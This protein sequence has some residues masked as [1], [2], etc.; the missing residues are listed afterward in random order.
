[1][2][3]QGLRQSAVRKTLDRPFVAG[4]GIPLCI[5]RSVTPDFWDVYR[6]DTDLMAYEACPKE[7]WLIMPDTLR[8][9]S[10]HTLRELIFSPISLEV[11]PTCRHD[12]SDS[13]SYLNPSRLNV[14][15]TFPCH[16]DQTLAY[17]GTGTLEE[18]DHSREKF[19]LGSHLLSG[20][21][22]GNGSTLCCVCN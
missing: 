14:S 9:T 12:F 11:M 13:K 21:R 17:W 22:E 18:G 19:G 20:T 7:D 16:V 10:W 2:E 15:C 4:G 8:T 1:M 6:E 3:S 5:P